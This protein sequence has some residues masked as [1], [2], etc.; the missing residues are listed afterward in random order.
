MWV[1]RQTTL[2]DY[3]RFIKSK[4]PVQ[5]CHI[6]RKLHEQSR[7]K[8]KSYIPGGL[9][10]HP[11]KTY[12]YQQKTKKAEGHFRKALFHQLNELIIRVPLLSERPEDILPIARL[13]LEH[14]SRGFRLFIQAFDC[15]VVAA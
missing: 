2:E 11:Q 8:N 9:K 14:F 10:L 6:S 12:H 3:I 13:F 5:P 15:L 7:R 4:D 1:Y